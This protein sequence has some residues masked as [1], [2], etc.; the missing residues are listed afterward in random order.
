MRASRRCSGCSTGWKEPVSGGVRLGGEPLPS[1]DGL[2]LRRSFG[3]VCQQPALL[4]VRDLDDLHVGKPELD[5]ETAAD[6][7]ER[8]RLP[9]R[10]TSG[11]SGGEAQRRTAQPILKRTAPE[12]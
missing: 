4:T 6:L 8:V 10:A 12:P 9:T 11:L 1:L 2:A 7:F 5:N 3:L